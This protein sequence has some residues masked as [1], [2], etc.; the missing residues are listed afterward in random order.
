MKRLTLLIGLL[1]PLLACAEGKPAKSA[2]KAARG[3]W[4]F[5]IS[6]DSRNCGDVVMPAI[7]AGARAQGVAF[8]WHLGDLR[9]LSKVD[10]DI[11]NRKDQP[12]PSLESYRA[13]A[14]QDF[15]DHQL[16]AWGQTAVFL[17]I[18]NHEL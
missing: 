15:I 10:E 17:G 3:P 11:V 14:W 2:G 5:A 6:G 16:R 9:W 8:Y 1:L 18:G 7:A 12:P 4:K 13:N